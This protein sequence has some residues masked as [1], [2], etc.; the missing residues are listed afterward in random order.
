M[1][2]FSPL[3]HLAVP[4]LHDG[5][6]PVLRRGHDWNCPHA[7]EVGSC[8]PAGWDDWNDRGMAGW[9]IRD[10]ARRSFILLRWNLVVLGLGILMQVGRRHRA[11]R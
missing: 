1:M 8:Y 6:V 2:F 7:T 5:S 9:G 3:I 11:K 4:L 10:V